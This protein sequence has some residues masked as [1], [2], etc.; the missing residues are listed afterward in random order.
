M[1]IKMRRVSMI[2]LSENQRYDNAVRRCLLNRIV[3]FYWEIVLHPSDM[4][5][6]LEC[7]YWMGFFIHSMMVVFCGSCGYNSL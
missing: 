5:I 6:L 1:K 2:F 4:R 3:Q 7:A